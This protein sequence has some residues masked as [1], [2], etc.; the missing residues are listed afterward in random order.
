MTGSRSRKDLIVLVADKDMEFALRGLLG[1]GQS[2]GI[3]MPCYDIL[4]HSGHDPGCFR[5]GHHLLRP[6][7]RSHTHALVIFDREG[8]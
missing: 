5:R 4:V 8:C 6:F 2:L 3:Y 7:Y 1:R